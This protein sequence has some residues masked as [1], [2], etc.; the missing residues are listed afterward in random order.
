MV[1][2]VWELDTK[3]NIAESKV[4]F[5]VSLIYQKL[6]FN[7]ESQIFIIINGLIINKQIV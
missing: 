6:G 5:L 1:L 2:N 4:M 3:L 7:A